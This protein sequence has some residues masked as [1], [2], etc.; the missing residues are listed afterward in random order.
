MIPEHWK[1][2]KKILDGAL[3]L[4]P[5][6]RQSYIRKHCPADDEMVQEL[7]S[8]LAIANED[9]DFLQTLFPV[10][11]GTQIPRFYTGERID[12]YHIDK[13]IG[14]GGMGSVYLAHR[15]DG[16]FE[17]DVAIKVMHSV[18]NDVESITRFYN[19]RQILARINHPNIVQIYDG[20]ILSDGLLYLVMEYVAGWSLLRYAEEKKLELRSR[21]LLFVDILRATH[22]LHENNIIHRDLKPSNILISHDGIVK[23]VDFGIAKVLDSSDFAL[24]P[25]LTRRGFQRYTPNYASPEQICHR[26]LTFQSDIFSLGIVLYELITGTRPFEMEG[27]SAKEIESLICDTIPPPPSQRAKALQ[28]SS[29]QQTA[30]TYTANERDNSVRAGS[31]DRISPD[32]D[33]IIMQALAKEPR[34][35]YSSAHDF[36][37]DIENHLAGRPVRARR[38]SFI[39][40]I[41]RL[42]RR[43]RKPMLTAFLMMCLI[44][45]AV[46][47]QKF[48]Q[49]SAGEREITGEE[50]SFTIT[51]HIMHRVVGRKHKMAGQLKFSGV[52]IAKVPVMLNILGGPNKG[53]KQETVTDELGQ[54]AFV[55]TGSQDVGRDTSEISYI[56]NIDGQPDSLITRQVY[57]GWHSAGTL[58]GPLG[59][60]LGRPLTYGALLGGIGCDGTRFSETLIVPSGSIRLERIAADS[61]GISIRLQKGDPEMLYD[62]EVFEA[63][64]GCG[65]SSLA[66]TGV[67]LSTTALGQGEAHFTLPLPWHPPK[68]H[69]LG[70]G[71]GTEAL[72]VVLDYVGS[73][74]G[75]DRFSTDP[76]PLPKLKNSD[77][78]R[79]LP[80]ENAEVPIANRHR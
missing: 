54:F 29:Q 19:E 33:S 37:V 31:L 36:A 12:K 39:G 26:E 24:K 9:T 6:E 1:K 18:L 55:Y 44:V 28:R 59:G 56:Y 47:W 25:V 71:H 78:N 65:S 14:S 32:L 52:A 79:N 8:L 63:G 40:K 75:G 10:N 62:I 72:I 2:I 42:P 50:I 61:L 7:E 16:Q 67:Q 70:D 43:H 48:G 49:G 30:A 66:K 51:P 45:A 27:K 77:K 69:S 17:Q 80:Q 74:K 58:F 64:V 21:L 5:Q 46:G 23:L 68:H 11:F 3:Q 34:M 53:I 76:I 60:P 13:S 41:V 4:P 22:Y 35:R 38:I 57:T 73:I 15:I 20:G